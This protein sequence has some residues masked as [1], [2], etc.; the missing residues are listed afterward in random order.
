MSVRAISRL[1]GIHKATILALLLT[2]GLNCA[3]LFDTKVRNL[4]PRY[5]QADEA[6]TFVQK[7]QKQLKADDPADYGDQYVWL[8]LPVKARLS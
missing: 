3:R 6:W 2:V 5:I 4:R 7:K 1:T 8:A